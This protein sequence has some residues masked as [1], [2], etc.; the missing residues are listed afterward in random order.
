MIRSFAASLLGFIGFAVLVA[1]ASA[2]IADTVV[3]DL[4]AVEGSSV[5]G[6]VILTASGERTF[7]DLG[8]NGLTPGATYTVTLHGGTCDQPSASF[9]ALPTL[10]AGADGRAMGSGEV[11]FHGTDPVSLSSIA[12]D[13]HVVIVADDNGVVA[14]AVIPPRIAAAIPAAAGNAGPEASHGGIA[15]VLGALGL[16]GTAALA[17]GAR[18]ATSPRSR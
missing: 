12:D 8:V 10:T 3:V 14:C 9:T 11:L 5:A 4:E 7:V 18:R 17:V 16:A 1:V 6:S 15:V 13:E 2:Q